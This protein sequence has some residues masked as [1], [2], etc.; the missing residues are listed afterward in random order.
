MKDCFLTLLK[1]CPYPFYLHGY[2][3]LKS[4]SRDV[5]ITESQLQYLFFRPITGDSIFQLS[6]PIVSSPDVSLY[7]R[8]SEYFQAIYAITTV[9]TTIA[10]V[11]NTFK[12]DMR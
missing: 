12:R 8:G 7:I 10:V 6:N 11:V 9:A 2:K 4:D 3:N 5:T 1:N